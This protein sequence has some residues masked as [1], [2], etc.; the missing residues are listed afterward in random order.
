AI[1]TALQIPERLIEPRE[2]GHQDGPTP[3][4]AAAIADLPDILDP[5]GVVADKAVAEGLE[6]AVDRLGMTLEARFTPAII[7]VVR[8]HAHEQPARRHAEG[9]DPPDL[10]LAPSG[11]PSGFVHLYYKTGAASLMRIGNGTIRV[12]VPEP[13]IMEIWR[14]WAGRTAI[15]RWTGARP[16]VV[17]MPSTQPAAASRRWRTISACSPC[18]T[19]VSLTP[20]RKFAPGSAISRCCWPGWSAPIAAG[21]R[22]LM[23]RCRPEPWSLP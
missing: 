1:M 18:L 7:A 20:R 14:A 11:Q 10:H 12:S 2:R 22:R 21:W 23:R 5:P 17:P 15:S 3:I 6:G 8:L 13:L 19:A 4:E 16:I 9:F